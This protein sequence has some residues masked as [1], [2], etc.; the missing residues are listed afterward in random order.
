MHILCNCYLIERGCSLGG[1]NLKFTTKSVTIILRIARHIQLHRLCEVSQRCLGNPNESPFP[2]ARENQANKGLA[3]LELMHQ[4]PQAL[5]KRVVAALYACQVLGSARIIISASCLRAQCQYNTKLALSHLN[6]ALECCCLG[7]NV[8][9][10][11]CSA[12]SAT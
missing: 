10:L 2:R 5:W 7:F 8:N 3:F 4:N 6:V 9:R 12:H 11:Q 1:H